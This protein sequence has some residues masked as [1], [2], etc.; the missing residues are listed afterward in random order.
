MPAVISMLWSA[1]WPV[2]AAAAFFFSGWHY[3]AGA[4]KQAAQAVAVKQ[5]FTA[6][7]NAQAATV[8][9]VERIK[10]INQRA[11]QNAQK[12][13]K[14]GVIMLGADY[15]LHHDAAAQPDAPAADS[16][17]ASAIDAAAFAHTVAFNYARCHENA[18]QLEALQHWAGG[19]Q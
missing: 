3:G 6:D 13:H 15:R 5:L 12:E 18:A 14:S 1:L 17:N 11:T 10:Y 4:E 16:A 19:L 8:T 9:Y 7:K 2:A